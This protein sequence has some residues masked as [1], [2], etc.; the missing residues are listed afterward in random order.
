MT[1]KCD[2]DMK[3]DR[4]VARR[5]VFWKVVLEVYT[6]AWITVIGIWLLSGGTGH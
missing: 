1:K 6:A 2:D 4:Q 3:V 5:I